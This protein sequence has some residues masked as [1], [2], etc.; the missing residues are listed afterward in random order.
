[1]FDNTDGRKRRGDG[2]EA[3]TQKRTTS[4]FR[5]LKL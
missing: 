2:G 3:P 5:T 4:P 1:M